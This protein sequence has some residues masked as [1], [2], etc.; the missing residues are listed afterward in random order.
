MAS[1][2][3]PSKPWNTLTKHNTIWAE[4]SRDSCLRSYLCNLVG[5]DKQI[6]LCVWVCLKITLQ[7]LKT[8]KSHSR[9]RTTS[10]SAQKTAALVFIT[11]ATLLHSVGN[12]AGEI[13]AFYTRSSCVLIFSHVLRC[14]FTAHIWCV[15]CSLGEVEQE[16]QSVN[17]S[18]LCYRT[19]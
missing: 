5:K 11:V 4:R 6:L 18:Y 3:V 7:L 15:S 16:L 10:Q 1:L 12:S 17:C 19:R 13:V 9:N 8:L 14:F 2:S